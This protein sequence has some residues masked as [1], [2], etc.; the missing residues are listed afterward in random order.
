MKV[1][2]PTLGVF[3]GRFNSQAYR[4]ALAIFATAF[5]FLNPTGVPDIATWVWLNASAFA[6]FVAKA[7]LFP[8]LAMADAPEPDRPPAEQAKCSAY[9]A[10]AI[11]HACCATAR[12]P[13]SY[14]F[15]LLLIANRF[16]DRVVCSRRVPP[17]DTEYLFGNPTNVSIGDQ[18]YSLGRTSRLRFVRIC[19][20]LQ[21]LFCPITLQH[22][23]RPA[24][25]PV[26]QIAAIHMASLNL[27]GPILIPTNHPNFSALYPIARRLQ[28]NVTVLCEKNDARKWNEPNSFGSAPLAWTDS[29][30]AG[31]YILGHSCVVAKVNGEH[32]LLVETPN[33]WL[34]ANFRADLT[35]LSE[36]SEW[37]WSP[38]SIDSFVR[39]NPDSPNLHCL[40]WILE[41]GTSPPFGEF[42]R[43]LRPDAPGKLYSKNK[44]RNTVV[45]WGQRK[46][47][48]SEIEFLTIASLPG[49]TVVYA[50]AAPCHHLPLLCRFFPTVKFILYDDGDVCEEALAC[51]NVTFHKRLFTDSDAA[52]YAGREDVLF[53]SD[54]R[55]R[56]SHSD[57]PQAIEA[58]V[59]SDMSTQ[60]YWHALMA[61][62]YSSLKFRLPWPGVSDMET[63]DYLDGTVHLPVWGGRSTSECRL[64]VKRDAERRMWDCRHFE[65]QMSFFNCTTRVSI[66]NQEVKADGLD[67]CYDCTAE[68]AIL[69]R[70]YEV[71]CSHAFTISESFEG[72][73]SSTVESFTAFLGAHNGRTLLSGNVKEIKPESSPI[74]FDAEEF[75]PLTTVHVPVGGLVP[76]P[77]VPLPYNFD[78]NLPLSSDRYRFIYRP[79]P[80]LSAHQ[81]LAAPTIYSVDVSLF[82]PPTVFRNVSTDVFGRHVAHPVTLDFENMDV[83][84]GTATVSGLPAPTD[85]WDGAS[86]SND[87]D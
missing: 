52:S 60:E 44:N 25:S 48:L 26:D 76:K 55:T 5:N 41:H 10:S 18:Q 4:M 13:F 42:T 3:R 46:L 35:A 78:G 37:W 6:T 56:G 71:A 36:K 58:M 9:V 20:M 50:G 23:P 29:I 57:T 21:N 17:F 83:R 69:R 61:P 31:S 47:L 16:M 54:I 22:V 80:G 43:V 51:P 14:V 73:A 87:V 33:S 82:P 7:R 79:D 65:E 30:P 85:L 81:C 1:T 62:R 66:Y 75:I 19:V 8:E 40:Q 67:H 72:W 64:F 59:W 53:V 32:V 34:C 2:P 15:R 49:D 84:Q 24:V 77:P 70:F 74:F 45:H 38:I 27:G 12:V 68:V 28:A 39:V 86:G 11:Y 63:V